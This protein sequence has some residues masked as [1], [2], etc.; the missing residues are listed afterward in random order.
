M[1][2]RSHGDAGVLYGDLMRIQI[3]VGTDPDHRGNAILV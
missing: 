3:A 1:P 2:W